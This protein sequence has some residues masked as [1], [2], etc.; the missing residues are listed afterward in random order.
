VKNNKV[1][2]RGYNKKEKKKN[3]IQHAEIVAIEK[4]C[5]KLKTWHLDDCQIYITMEPCLMCTGAIVQAR[6]SKVYYGI[7]NEKF[8]ISNYFD[9]NGEVKIN[10]HYIQF[11]G[12]YLNSDIEKMLKTFFKEKREKK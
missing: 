4:A 7:R 1:I 11:Y 2:A 3:A 5:K 10:N 8:G 12:G 9:I 6:I